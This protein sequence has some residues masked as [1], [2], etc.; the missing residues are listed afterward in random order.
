MVDARFVAFAGF[1]R[2]L[3]SE[4][5][6]RTSDDEEHSEKQVA[7]YAS[8]THASTTQPAQIIDDSPVAAAQADVVL[9]EED[10]PDPQP[11]PTCDGCCPNPCSSA[12]DTTLL[13]EPTQD[14][15][16]AIEDRVIVAQSWLVQLR[17]I[18]YAEVLAGEVETWIVE[19]T[20]F[21]SCVDPKCYHFPGDGLVGDT[22]HILNVKY[23]DLHRAA[24]PFV[25]DAAETEITIADEPIPQKR[26]RM[27]KK[28]SAG[29]GSTGE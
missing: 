12:L 29:T 22:I 13:Q 24:K 7:M 11:D 1:G 15:I 21:V 16:E 18:K 14:A 4:S 8:T 19:A 9:D 28:C 2:R 26:R 5:D 20:E 10:H 6:P 17:D 23:W 3:G 25:D 27:S